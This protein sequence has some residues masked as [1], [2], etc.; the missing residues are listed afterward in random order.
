MIPALFEATNAARFETDL[1]NASPLVRQIRGGRAC[2]GQVG[3]M[4]VPRYHAPYSIP[5]LAFAGRKD[6]AGSNVSELA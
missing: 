1:E 5:R 2:L 6:E 4:P 3:S